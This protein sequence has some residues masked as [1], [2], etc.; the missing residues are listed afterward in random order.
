MR[1]FRREVLWPAAWTSGFGGAS[2]FSF[3]KSDQL[4]ESRDVEAAEAAYRAEGLE[5]YRHTFPNDPNPTEEEIDEFLSTVR[6]L[7]DTFRYSNFNYQNDVYKGMMD[8]YGSIH[9][10]LDE[11]HDA[12]IEALGP[13]AGYFFLGALTAVGAVVLGGFTAASTKDYIDDKIYNWRRKRG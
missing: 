8:R 3:S 10:E 13:I 7:D 9:G 4:Y 2:F 1:E 5:A 11:L 12:Y 6:D